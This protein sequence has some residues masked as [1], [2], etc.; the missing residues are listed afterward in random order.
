MIDRISDD[1]DV[2]NSLQKPRKISIVSS[3]G[4]SRYFLCK[5]N[6]DLKKDNRFIELCN[7]IN[8][9]LAKTFS[10]KKADYP[11]DS[12]LTYYVCPI[13]QTVGIIEWVCDTMPLRHILTDMYMRKSIKVS[14]TAVKKLM[15]ESCDKQ[16]TFREVTTKY[17]PPI[18]FAW[19]FV[20]FPNP[21]KWICARKNYIV[22]SAY[23]S[24]IGYILGLGDRHC[25][26][27]L[28]SLNSGICMHVDFNCLF[29]KVIIIFTIRGDPLKFPNLY[30]LGSRIILLT[31]WVHSGQRATST[32]Q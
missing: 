9:L 18:F 1:F 2:L 19:F 16:A 6:D 25:E 28:Y 24:I 4:I 12:I 29:D 27:L 10:D 26:N 7:T 22:S 31:Q 17:Y 8:R 32:P 11:F 23:Y 5:P 15:D 21:N 3:D 14:F 20:M 13:T 30:H